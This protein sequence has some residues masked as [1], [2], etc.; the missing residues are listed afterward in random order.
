MDGLRLRLRLRVQKVFGINRPIPL[1]TPRFIRMLSE[2]L[3]G[4]DKM[5][6]KKSANTS[7][8]LSASIAELSTSVEEK[9]KE[10]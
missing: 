2:I 4:M 7:V 1:H 9:K 6:D 10:L 5:Y 8:S 3:N